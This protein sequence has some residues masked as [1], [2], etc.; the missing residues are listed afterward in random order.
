M[1]LLICEMFRDWRCDKP[2]T[3]PFKGFI[4]IH[5]IRL[6]K[7]GKN[8]W[9][10]LMNANTAN[11]EKN[12]K[13]QIN[14]K[15]RASYAFYFVGQNIFY[16]LLTTYLNTYFL[17]IGI[18]A[19]VLSGLILAVKV[20]DAIN[21]PIFGGIVD[22]AKFKNGKFLPWLRV[23]LIAIP[24]ATILLFAIPSSVPAILKIVWAAIGYMMWD[25]AYTICDVPIF[26]IVTTMTSSQDERVSLMASGRIAAMAAAVVVTILVPQFRS[27][28]GGWFPMAVILSLLG[29][30]FM[31]PICLTA[32]ERIKPPAAEK[33][34]SFKEMISFIAKNKYMLI[35]YSAVIIS[36]ATVIGTPLG[37]IISRSFWGDEGLTTLL[38]LATIIP[39]VLLGV[40][41]PKILK[42]VDK[43]KLF[44]FSLI[45]GAVMSVVIYF[46]GYQ[47]FS[48]NLI[49]QAI[50]G[51]PVGIGIMIMFMFT[52]DCAEYSTYKL[53]ISASGVAFSI[54]TFSVKLTGAL[55]SSLSAFALFLV[56]YVSAEGAVQHAGFNGRLWM[57]YNL[58]PAA[59][60]LAGAMIFRFYKLRDKDVQIM[61]KANSGEITRE[62]ATK[63]LGGRYE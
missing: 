54:Q 58:I 45:G 19:L 46:T 20:W 51:I 9:R 43:Y 28:I 41:I 32:K 2:H 25:T 26:G 21:D 59:G 10:V 36:Q 44:L 23:S 47:N 16:L 34:V 35:F 29:L 13:R 12:S 33:D 61:T 22:R 38:T 57:A 7:T 55:A 31:I 18:S 37:L 60:Y 49:L 53:G 24:A 15:E 52:P 4:L 1:L 40:F 30:L 63:L 56:G 62:E 6:L 42:K 8:I 5:N 17:D 48:I 11:I 27:I 39:A 14:G 3:F 50:K